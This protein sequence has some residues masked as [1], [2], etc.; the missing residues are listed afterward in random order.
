MWFGDLVTMRWWDDLWLNES[1]ATW[2][3]TEAQARATRWDNSWTTFTTAA[4]TNTD[5]SKSI[6][7]SS[8][9]GA[10]A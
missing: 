4:R 2:A 6:F 10:A 5:W 3:G 1:F 8:P 9:F 7:S